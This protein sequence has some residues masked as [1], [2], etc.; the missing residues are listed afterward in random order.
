MRV[1]TPGAILILALAAGCGGA[2]SADGTGS[3]ESALTDT[4]DRAI[5]TQIHDGG[6]AVLAD[7]CSILR[8]TLAAASSA[9][10]SNVKVASV[11]G[12][13]AGQSVV[14]DSGGNE[15]SSTIVSVGTAGAAGT[16]VTLAPPLSIA[17]A[18]GVTVMAAG[19]APG[20]TLAGAVAAGDTDIKVASSSWFVVG[21]MIAIDQG[22]NQETRTISAV[23]TSGAAGTGIAFTPSLVLAHPAGA[24]VVLQAPVRTVSVGDAIHDMAIVSGGAVASSASDREILT[25]T[26]YRGGTCAVSHASGSESDVVTLTGGTIVNTYSDDISGRTLTAGVYDPSTQP[27]YVV[28]SADAGTLWFVAVWTFPDAPSRASACEQ[29]TVLSGDTTPPTIGIAAPAVGATYL[30]GSTVLAAYACRDEVG[31]SAVVSCVGTAANGAPVDTATIGQKTFTVNAADSAG[32]TA[33]AKSV[34]SVVY[35]FAGFFAP[36][37]NPPAVNEARAG[38]AIPVMFSLGDDQGASILAG[39]A[40]SSRPVDCS[41]GAAGPSAPAERGSL[42]YDPRTQRYTFVWKTDKGWAGT[43]RELNVKLVDGSEHKAQFRFKCAAGVG[44]V[45]P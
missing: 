9:G 38:S 19:P 43:C 5:C 44:P 8:T 16:G 30:L 13:S 26:L 39:G 7:G 6:H 37:A 18:S 25:T 33:S 14:I 23:G 1:T 24:A 10:D 29:L 36:I 21:Q 11:S 4:S 22:P 2:R 45:R 15:E 41:S 28:Q 17:H 3:R 40:P 35:G 32:N 27:D 42:S 31:G 34:Y 12:L 20:T